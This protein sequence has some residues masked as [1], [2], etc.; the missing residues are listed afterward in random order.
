VILA[1]QGKRDDSDIVSTVLGA[2]LAVILAEA[3]ADYVGTMIGTG[4][5][6]TWPELRA[7]LAL[8]FASL[9]AVVPPIVLSC[10]ASTASTA[11]TRASPPP[12]SRGSS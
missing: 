6:P 1:L 10:S 4:L 11:S 2:L 8:T 7:Q 3:Y 9:L 5:R 12:R